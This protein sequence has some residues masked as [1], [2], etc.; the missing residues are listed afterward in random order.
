MKPLWLVFFTLAGAFA[1]GSAT[2]SSLG[3]ISPYG[4]GVDPI[5]PGTNGLAL[6]LNLGAMEFPPDDGLVP[7]VLLR[8]P[9]PLRGV[10]RLTA[11]LGPE[12]DGFASL[13]LG[14]ISEGIAGIK[15]RVLEPGSQG[16]Y[17]PSVAIRLDVRYYGS[18]NGL[19]QSWITGDGINAV[20]LAQMRGSQLATNGVSTE[21][22]EQLNRLSVAAGWGLGLHRHTVHIAYAAPVYQGSDGY[23][24]ADP[25][26]RLHWASGPMPSGA[27]LVGWERTRVSLDPVML[28]H[29]DWGFTPTYAVYFHG[30][31][32]ADGFGDPTGVVGLRGQW[33][34]GFGAEVYAGEDRYG[35][36]VGAGLLTRFGRMTD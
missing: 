15:V 24:W 4:L 3:D 13:E 33:T 27:Y 20:A 7:D 5:G 22:R 10:A 17:T 18:T 16:R 23:W 2:A 29:L 26:G 19:D 1:R 34:P 32:G 6:N 12:V 30:E 14:D 35:P 36:L 28:V 11:G 8:V 25:Q 21:A 31:S 9:M